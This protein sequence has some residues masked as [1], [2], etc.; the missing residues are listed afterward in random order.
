M[1]RTRKRRRRDRSAADAIPVAK[2]DE[3][4]HRLSS[5]AERA[6]LSIRTVRH[7]VQKGALKVCHVGPGRVPR[8]ADSELRRYL[9]LKDT[10]GRD[11]E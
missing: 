8:V 2:V 11:S 5:V 9:G 3:K 1:A 7:H 10:P 4:L 6:D